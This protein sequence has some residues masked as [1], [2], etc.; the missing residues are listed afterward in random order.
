MIEIDLVAYLKGYQPLKDLIGTR[1]H[2][3][4][5]PEK[6]D[7]P[8]VAYNEVSAPGYHDIDVSFPRFQFSCFHSRYIEAKQVRN[9]IENAL[10][11]F[12]GKMGNTRVIQGVVAGKYETYEKDTKLHNAIIDI[13][14][15]YWE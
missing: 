7:M 2:P 5:I 11:R 4:A 3:G 9:E 15:I 13:K 12:K 14:I 8:A 1:I 6:A 10:K